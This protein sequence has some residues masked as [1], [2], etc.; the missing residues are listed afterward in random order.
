MALLPQIHIPFAEAP[1]SYRL[2]IP[3]RTS[4]SCLVVC[5]WVSCGCY[6]VYTADGSTIILKGPSYLHCTFAGQPNDQHQS[7]CCQFL[8]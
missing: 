6:A 4:S 5:V 3:D 1:R 2:K 8:I 7:A